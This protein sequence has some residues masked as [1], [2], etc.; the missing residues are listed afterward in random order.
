MRPR[1]NESDRFGVTNF[2]FSSLHTT[3]YNNA[4]YQ[5]GIIPGACFDTSVLFISHPSESCALDGRGTNRESKRCVTKHFFPQKFASPRTK[6][7]AALTRERKCTAPTPLGPPQP[8]THKRYQITI[9]YSLAVSS[10]YFKLCLAS[11]P[12]SNRSISL[13]PRCSS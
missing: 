7:D 8:Q 2:S 13:F 4:R 3:L 9:K 5:V 11:I 6:G 12:A 1:T 10:T